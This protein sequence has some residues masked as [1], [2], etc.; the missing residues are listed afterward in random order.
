VAD[1]SA[2]DPVKWQRLRASWSS[3]GDDGSSGGTSA[4]TQ[5][6]SRRP[7]IQAHPVTFAD[8]EKNAVKPHLKEQWCL[9]PGEPSGEF[10]ARMEDVLE[11]YTGVRRAAAG[12]CID[13]SRA[14][15]QR[16]PDSAF[17][18]APAQRPGTTTSTSVRA[19]PTCS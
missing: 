18:S 10:V 14:I 13:E 4:V 2:A 12:V 8:L 9:P 1:L 3:V 19:S 17:W 6:L 7:G 15:G 16:G 5:R 11:V